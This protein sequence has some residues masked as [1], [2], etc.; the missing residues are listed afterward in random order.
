MCIVSELS[1]NPTPPDYADILAQFPRAT[2]AQ[3]IGC[4]AG[5]I[6]NILSGCKPPG[7]KLDLK[8]RELATAVEAEMSQ[9]GGQK[10][11]A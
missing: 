2:V 10:A 11:H 8:L 3:K 6:S 9:Q 7:R 4:S 1:K 5:Y